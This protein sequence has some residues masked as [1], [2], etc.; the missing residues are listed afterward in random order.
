[1]P[2]YHIDPNPHRVSYGTT[3]GILLSNA[4][5]PCIPGDVAN[6]STFEL[7][8]AYRVVDDLG[9]KLGKSALA[10]ALDQLVQKGCLFSHEAE[11]A[12]G[13]ILAGNARALYRID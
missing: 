4:H 11:E 5:V 7:P 10:R 9:A 2:V 8:V 13:L 3:I 6:A 12:A 1:M